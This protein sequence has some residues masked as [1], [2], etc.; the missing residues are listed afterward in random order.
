M[1]IAGVVP[2][3]KHTDVG[4]GPDT[5]VLMPFAQKPTTAVTLAVEVDPAVYRDPMR[6]A[7]LLRKAVASVDKAQAVHRVST[8]EAIM[9]DRLSM[10]RLSTVVLALFAGLALLLASVGIYGVLAYAVEQRA[11][12]IGVRMAMGAEARDVV[13]ILVRQAM[14]LALAGIAVGVAGALAAN[15]LFASL[16]HGVTATDPR[17]FAAAALLLLTVAAMAGYLPARRAT[18]VDPLEA[19][20]HE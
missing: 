11:H 8:M 17:T 6:L 19:L 7:P 2:D 20:R 9:A 1:T 5:E 13:R 4:L 18:R 3:I 10:R 12:E 14:I 16:L 15:R